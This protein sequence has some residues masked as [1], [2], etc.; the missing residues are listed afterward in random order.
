MACVSPVPF[1]GTSAYVSLPL[2]CLAR[3]ILAIVCNAV[4]SVAVMLLLCLPL[5]HSCPSDVLQDPVLAV[6]CHHLS[7]CFEDIFYVE[8]CAGPEVF[9]VALLQG[10]LTGSRRRDW[11]V[12]CYC[13][14]LY[15]GRVAPR[16]LPPVEFVV[17]AR[18][19]RPLAA[20]SLRLVSW[21]LLAACGIGWDRVASP[22]WAVPVHLPLLHPA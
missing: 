3:W 2:L 12:P 8:F 5:A 11:A 4:C 15:T 13:W 7:C 20:C 17:A 10:Q 1:F 19:C 18:S 6:R 9:H 14:L 21:L 22:H 16:E